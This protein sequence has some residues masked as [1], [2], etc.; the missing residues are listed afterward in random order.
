MKTASTLSLSTTKP[1]EFWRREGEK[2]EGGREEGG[3][4]EGGRKGGGRERR[5]REEE[6]RRK[7]R[8]VS[9]VGEERGRNVC[10]LTWITS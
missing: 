2:R 8:E 3:R 9:E 7:N 10:T 4:V 1:S 5:G 6:R